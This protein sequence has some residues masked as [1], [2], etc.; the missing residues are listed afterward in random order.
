MYRIFDT[1]VD[2]SADE[3]Q[4]EEKKIKR[5]KKKSKTQE[6]EGI[7][8][9]EVPPSSMKDESGSHLGVK[10]KNSV[11]N[12]SQVRMLKDGVVVEELITGKPDGK[13]ACQG[14]KAS[15]F[16]SVDLVTRVYMR[17]VKG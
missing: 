17:T 7:M 6:K 9:M 4:N 16:Y 3:N 14:K 10:D 8:N 13:I 11:V 5:K 15:L 1:K 2:Q 12:S